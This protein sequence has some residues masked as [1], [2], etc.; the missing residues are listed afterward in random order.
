MRER[1]LAVAMI[2]VYIAVIVGAGMH[3]YLHTVGVCSYPLI[4]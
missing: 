2:A 4:Q 1:R 3:L